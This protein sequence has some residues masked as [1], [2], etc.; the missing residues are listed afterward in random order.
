MFFFLPLHNK[1]RNI[2][3]LRFSIDST[4]NFPLTSPGASAVAK[5]KADLDRAVM[6]SVLIDLQPVNQVN[7]Y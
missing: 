2:W 7:R 1:F 4:Q 6:A 5:R 3:V